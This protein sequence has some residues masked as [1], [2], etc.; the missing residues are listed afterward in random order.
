MRFIA[1][2][3]SLELL[4]MTGYRA[5]GQFMSHGLKLDTNQVYLLDNI[6]LTAIACNNF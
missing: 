6:V 1:M 5:P 4:S 3:A 2:D